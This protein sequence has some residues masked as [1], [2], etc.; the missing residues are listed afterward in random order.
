[1]APKQDC[2]QRVLAAVHRAAL[3]CDEKIGW[4]RIGIALSLTLIAVA[5]VIRRPR[6]P[7]AVGIPYVRS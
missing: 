6:P 5:G 2:E 3:F 1:M 4:N 7:A